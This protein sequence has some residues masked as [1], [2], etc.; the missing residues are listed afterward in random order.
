MKYSLTLRKILR[1]ERE[2]FSKGSGYILPYIL[3]QVIIQTLSISKKDTSSMVLPGW[4]ILEELIFRIALAT[5]P[6]FSS[7]GPA[8]KI[9]PS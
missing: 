8:Q 1:V 9:L 3:T 2:G 6:I 7:N 4:L 5:G